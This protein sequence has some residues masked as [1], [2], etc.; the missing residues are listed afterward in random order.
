MCI[1]LSVFCSTLSHSSLLL[2]SFFLFFV[3]LSPQLDHI[4][5]KA[6]ILNCPPPQDIDICSDYCICA[7]RT[8]VML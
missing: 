6:V 5:K 3:S 2:F 8:G 1:F 4:R 7:W